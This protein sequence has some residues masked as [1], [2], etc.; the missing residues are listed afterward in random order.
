MLC[1]RVLHAVDI[2]KKLAAGCELFEIL[3]NLCCDLKEFVLDAVGFGR[4]HPIHQGYIHK[5]ANIEKKPKPT[6][7]T[8]TRK[9]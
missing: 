5:C 2:L 3:A 6:Q 9:K 4:A 7:N 8:T 1:V